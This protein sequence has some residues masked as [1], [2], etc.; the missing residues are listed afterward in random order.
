M[1]RQIAMIESAAASSAGDILQLNTQVQQ[2]QSQAQQDRVS[3][4][5][6]MA[7]SSTAMEIAQHVR[8]AEQPTASVSGGFSLFGF[9]LW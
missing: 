7:M 3:N 1:Q 6:R 9:R 8:S 4:S 2:L 5:L